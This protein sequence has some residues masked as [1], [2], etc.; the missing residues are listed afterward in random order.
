MYDTVAKQAASSNKHSLLHVSIKQARRIKVL[1]QR[2]S[3]NFFTK[4]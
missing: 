2:G 4:K 3:F 1:K